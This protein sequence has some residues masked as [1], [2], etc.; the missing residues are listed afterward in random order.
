MKSRPNFLVS[1]IVLALAGSTLFISACG[2][3]A[4]QST[5]KTL[6]STPSID[7]TLISTSV[8]PTASSTFRAEVWADNW[9]SLYVNGQLVGEDSVPI[10]TERSF[11]SEALTF[12][13][14]YP[15]T[16]A[17]VTKDFKETD[18]GLEYIGEGNQQMGDGGFIAQFTDLSTG[19]VVATTS[20]N[21]RG[22][23]IQ[24]APLNVACEKSSDPNTDC[25]FENLEEPKG[26][27]TQNFDDSSWVGAST[28]TPQEVGTK[29]GYDTI[30]WDDSA[31]LIWGSNLK[32]HNTILWRIL[33]P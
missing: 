27:V 22:F 18:S 4:Q 33:I 32:T 29:D 31:E 23:V 16:I 28:Y 25:L 19:V 8:A 2:S 15:L 3:D 5:D 13:A 9:F 7:E 26:W 12:E 10:T 30:K 21:W 24:T 17:M 6:I 1:K 14:T 20:K 11:N